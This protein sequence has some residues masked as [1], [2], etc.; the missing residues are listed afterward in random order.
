MVTFKLGFNPISGDL[1]TLAGISKTD[2]LIA[3]IRDSSDNVLQSPVSANPTTG[4]ITINLANARLRAGEEYRLHI[5]SNQNPTIYSIT[6]DLL[7]TPDEAEGN[8][9]QGT[10]KDLDNLG[11][12]LR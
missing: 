4:I 1:L 9:T 10:A 12:S 2:G 8:D 5:K 6:F 7:S 11:I 3:E